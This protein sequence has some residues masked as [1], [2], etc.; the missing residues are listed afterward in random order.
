MISTPHEC[1]LMAQFLLGLEKIPAIGPKRSII[2]GDHSCTSTTSKPSQVGT[3]HEAFR[4]EFTLVGVLRGDD[5]GVDSDVRPHEEPAD[6]SQ[7]TVLSGGGCR[8]AALAELRRGEGN[9]A[10]VPAGGGSAGAGKEEER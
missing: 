10:A 6:R 4:N 2:F 3:S 5:V 8:A 9:G 7:L 1:P